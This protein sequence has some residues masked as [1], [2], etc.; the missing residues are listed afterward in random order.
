MVS[1]SIGFL[2]KYMSFTSILTSWSEIYSISIIQKW[3]LHEPYFIYG[4]MNFQNFKKKKWLSSFFNALLVS[5]A[6][7]LSLFPSI[8]FHF[9]VIDIKNICYTTRYWTLNIRWFFFS[10]RRLY[11][12]TILCSDLQLRGKKINS[13]K[14]LLLHTKSVV[15][16]YLL[17]CFQVLRE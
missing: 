7:L 14:L 2:L 13:T 8:L 16:S 5:M 6:T 3:S 1:G 15:P 17:L 4:C 9:S 12:C 10:K 11:F